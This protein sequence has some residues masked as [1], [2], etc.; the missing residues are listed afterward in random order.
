MDDMRWSSMVPLVSGRSMKSPVQQLL[1]ATA[2][3]STRDAQP[4]ARVRSTNAK[5]PAFDLERHI[6]AALQGG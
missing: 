5:F 2:Y 3:P 6:L 1:G 4:L